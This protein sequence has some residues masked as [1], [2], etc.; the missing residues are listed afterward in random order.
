MVS[1]CAISKISS[2]K[3]NANRIR[4]YV[5]IATD[6]VPFST[7]ITVSSEHPAR[8][9]ICAILIS[10]RKRAKRICSP[11]M[12]KFFWALRGRRI[13]CVD[14]LIISII[15]HI[16]KQ[17]LNK[18]YYMIVISAAKVLFFFKLRK[19][20]RLKSVSFNKKCD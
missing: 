8:S 3:F 16:I 15:Y 20:V 12:V 17:I 6:G 7:R 11:T 19:K 13:L 14:L 2:S 4:R 1:C 5:P 18:L 9:A 10:R